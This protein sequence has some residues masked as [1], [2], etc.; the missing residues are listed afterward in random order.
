[1]PRA[2]GPLNGQHRPVGE[3]VLHGAVEVRRVLLEPRQVALM[4]RGVRDG[5]VAIV[6]QAIREEIVQDSPVLAAEHRVLGAA[7]VD[8][9]NVVREQALEEVGRSR[10]RGLDLAHMRD[11][12]DSA[13]GSHRQVLGTDPFVLNG[14]LPAG[15]RHQACTGRLVGLEE[16]RAAK[17][18][19]RA[20]ASGR[21]L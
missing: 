12:E 4:V 17:V 18:R 14:H 16:W 7:Y 6:G 9:G 20:Q 13:P 10:A 1:M 15:E 2:S 5:Q 21:E 11:V 19:H 8:R 3:A